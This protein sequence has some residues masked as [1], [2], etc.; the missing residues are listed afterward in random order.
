MFAPGH[1]GELTRFIDFALVDAMLEET[2]TV[3]RRL[4]VLP[5]R[6]VVYFMRTLD[7]FESYSYRTAWAAMTSSRTPLALVR[8]AVSSLSRAHRRIGAA[9]LKLL[10]DTLA[11]PVGDP[12]R[13]GVFWRG[14][15]CVAVDGTQLHAPDDAQVTWRYPKRAGEILEFGYPLLRL[16]ALWGAAPVPCWPRPSP[17]RTRANSPMPGAFSAHWTRRC[18]CSPT[19]ASTPTGSTAY[20]PAARSSW[21]V[22]PP[23][24]SPPPS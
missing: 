13:P 4:G 23:A 12:G 6:V 5:S 3:Q 15:R 22:P 18:C 20:A 17:P 1:L 8:P 11:G 10:F 24:V 7:L 19:P 14:L 16:V 21:S 9:P 2:G